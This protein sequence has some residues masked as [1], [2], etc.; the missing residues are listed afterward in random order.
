[1]NKL[2]IIKYIITVC[3]ILIIVILDI[4]PE[5]TIYLLHHKIIEMMT[6]IKNC[7]ER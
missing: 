4:A 2:S 7:L 3:L 5:K 1:M 6:H